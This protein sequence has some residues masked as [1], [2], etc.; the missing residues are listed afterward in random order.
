MAELLI[1]GIMAAV[2]MGFYLLLLLRWEKVKRPLAYLFGCAGL[3][4]VLLGNFFL[5]GSTHT[6]DSI[7]MVF[8]CLGILA[9]AVGAFGACYPGELPE[10]R[11]PR[12]ETAGRPPITIDKI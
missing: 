9:A 11:I 3:V 8:Y 5:V 10:I 4:V 1:F 6:G 2:L 7:A 12:K